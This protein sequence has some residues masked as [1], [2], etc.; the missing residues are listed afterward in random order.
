VKKEGLLCG[1]WMV[2]LGGK[3]LDGVRVVVLLCG[4][5]TCLASCELIGK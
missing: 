2:V 3:I 5:L 4:R 1:V